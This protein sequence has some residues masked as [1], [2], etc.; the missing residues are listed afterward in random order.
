VIEEIEA[1]RR[2]VLD[3]LARLEDDIEDVR[4][5]DADLKELQDAARA[6]DRPTEPAP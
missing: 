5:L 3:I 6:A 4:E 2:K 1:L